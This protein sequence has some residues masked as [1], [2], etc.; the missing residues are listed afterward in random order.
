V[1]GIGAMTGGKAGGYGSPSRDRVIYVTTR[2]IGHQVEVQVKDGSIY[3]GI[4]HATNTTE[5][6]FG[7]FCW[8]WFC[9]RDYFFDFK[10][11]KW[12]QFLVSVEVFS[13]T[14][15]ILFVNNIHLLVTHRNHLENGALDKG[16]FCTRAEGY[17]RVF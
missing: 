4:F 3:S 5:K 7:M 1:A 9:L 14:H 17:C 11:C 12:I 10:C 15:A 2:L 8:I 16:L 13:R 6:D